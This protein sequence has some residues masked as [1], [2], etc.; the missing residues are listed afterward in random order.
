MKSLLNLSVLSLTIV[1][2]SCGKGSSS[3]ENEIDDTI[4]MYQ[5]NSDTSIKIEIE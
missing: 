1:L 4:K 3:G 5:T 2:V